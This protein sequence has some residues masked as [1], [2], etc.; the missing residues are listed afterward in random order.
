[1]NNKYSLTEGGILK[2][3]LLVAVPIM[4]THLMQMAYNLTDLFW[5]GRLGSAAAGAAGMCLAR[6]KGKGKK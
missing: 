5:L 4:G 3:L 6:E 1:M 2:K